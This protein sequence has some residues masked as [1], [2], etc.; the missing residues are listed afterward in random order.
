[1]LWD[2]PEHTGTLYGPPTATRDSAGGTT[3]AW[4][5]IRQA[6]IPCLI[7]TAGASEQERFRQQQ[8][9]VTHT[10]SI[11]RSALTTDPARG[12]KFTSSE[13]QSFHVHGISLGRAFMNIPAFVY[14]HCEELL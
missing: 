7:N 3:I 10:V 4:P 13:G 6:S 12:D 5:T 8:I 2:N 14:L 1:M 11:L 9:V